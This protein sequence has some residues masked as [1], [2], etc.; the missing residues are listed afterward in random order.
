MIGKKS[1]RQWC[2]EIAARSL[3]LA[4]WA[5]MLWAFVCPEQLKCLEQQMKTRWQLNH[6]STFKAV[7]ASPSKSW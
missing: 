3:G 7:S 1:P 6:R 4:P 2:L 5:R